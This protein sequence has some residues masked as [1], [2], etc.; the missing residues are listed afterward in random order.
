[1]LEALRVH[2]PPTPDPQ[3]VLVPPDLALTSRV[4]SDSE[5]PIAAG[6]S[7]IYSE[8]ES[9]FHTKLVGPSPNSFRCRSRRLYLSAAAAAR[10][11]PAATRSVALAQVEVPLSWRG[12]AV[13]GPGAGARRVDSCSSAGRWRPVALS[14]RVEGGAGRVDFRS[15]AG[16]CQ[17]ALKTG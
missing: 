2:S 7:R 6:A 12:A 4:Y 9:P 16:R 11:L 1:M 15:S 8:F 14:W 13:P 3:S 5:S 10:H 17:P